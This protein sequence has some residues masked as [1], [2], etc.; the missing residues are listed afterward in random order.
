MM[1]IELGGRKMEENLEIRISMARDSLI[2]LEFEL[3]RV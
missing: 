1:A 3:E 2:L